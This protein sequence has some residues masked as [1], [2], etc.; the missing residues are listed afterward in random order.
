MEILD[1]LIE[2]IKKDPAL[3]REQVRF[4]AV[5][6]AVCVLVS[7]FPVFLIVSGVPGF[8]WPAVFCKALKRWGLCVLCVACPKNLFT[9]V[10]PIKAMPS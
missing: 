1:F 9:G 10:A 4:L 8:H 5:S 2:L 6:L 3:G 7:L